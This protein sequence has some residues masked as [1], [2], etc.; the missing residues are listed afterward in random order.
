MSAE[1]RFAHSACPEYEALLEDYLGGALC[2]A[3]VAAVAR[4]IE[5][6]PNCRRAADAALAGTRMLREIGESLSQLSGAGSFEAR[7]QPSPAFPRIVMARIRAAEAE[8]QADYEG[9]WRT[10]V[11]LGRKFA[12]TATMAVALLA[13]YEAHSGGTSQPN[14]AAALPADVREMFSPDPVSLPANEGEALVMVTET[15]HANN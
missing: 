3:N 7:P 1:M 6:C 5:V 14:V 13:A 12:L 8:R 15:Y 4:H 10:L 2:D 9:F 11:S